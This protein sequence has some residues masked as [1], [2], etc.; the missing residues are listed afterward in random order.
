[1]TNAVFLLAANH[2]QGERIKRENPDLGITHVVT[3]ASGSRDGIRV[4]R[5][6][7]QPYAMQD[8]RAHK[9][10]LVLRRSLVKSH[11]DPADRV[12]FLDGRV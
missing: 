12:H 4:E 6:Y 2:A 7:V 10:L 8:P 5:V 3:P 9:H 11:L 1:V